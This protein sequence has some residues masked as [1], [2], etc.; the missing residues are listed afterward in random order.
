MRAV[1]LLECAA[2]VLELLDLWHD[3]EVPDLRRLLAQVL[4]VLQGLSKLRLEQGGAAFG[5]LNHALELLLARN[6]RHEQLLEN[7]LHDE[8]LFQDLLQARRAVL[9]LPT[10]LL[11]H[12]LSLLILGILL[13]EHS[14]RA[15]GDLRSLFFDGLPR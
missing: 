13:Q 3:V 2:V 6:C 10:N 1:E 12:L 4:L 9:V 11:D 15:G 7:L 14:E 5:G 8:E